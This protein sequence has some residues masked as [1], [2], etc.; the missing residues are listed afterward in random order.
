[1]FLREIVE[2]KDALKAFNIPQEAQRRQIKS[3]NE[4]ISL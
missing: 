3:K 1:M 2:Q 4:R